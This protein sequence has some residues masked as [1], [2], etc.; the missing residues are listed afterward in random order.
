LKK[1]DIQINIEKYYSKTDNQSRWAS[2]DYC[3]NYF[4][5]NKGQV[6]VNELEKSCLVLG[7]Y[8]ASWGMFRGNSNLSQNSVALYKP[9]ISYISKLDNS[10]WEID[11]DSYNEK[12]IKKIIEVYDEIKKLIIPEN[13]HLTVVTKILLGVFGMVPAFDENFCR[14]F[15]EIYKGKKGGGFRSLNKN[16]LQLIKDFYESNRCEIDS[17]YNNLFTTDFISGQKT[18]IVYSRAKIIDMYGFELGKNL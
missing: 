3:Y 14:C 2:F 11:V 1:E 17:Y 9:L 13:T 12:N 7:F 10:Y 5:K 16:S 18:N 6:L 8:L 4:Y 15:R